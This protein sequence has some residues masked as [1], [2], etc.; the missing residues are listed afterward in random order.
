VA[1]IQL[2]EGQ[3]RRYRWL[4]AETFALT[5]GAY[6]VIYFC[7]KNF[8]VA[9]DA[10][11]AEH[12]LTNA[13]LGDLDSGYLVAYAAGQ[14]LSGMLGD[15]IG[16]K[17]LVGFGLLATAAMNVLF[18]MGQ[19]FLFF[20]AAWT[21]NGVA[22]SSGWPGTLK[23]LTQWYPRGE[24]GTVLGIW[25]TCYQVGGV[26]ATVLATWLLVTFG[27]QSAFFGPAVAVAG[28]ALLFLSLQKGSPEDEGLPGPEV[29]R[30]EARGEPPPPAVEAP[31]SEGHFWEGVGHVLRSGPIWTLGFTYV[32]LKF[33]R[34]SFLFWLPFYMSRELGYSAGEAGYSS[35]AF[36]L[37]GVGGTVIAGLLSDRLFQSRRAPIVV[38]M[39]VLLAMATWL[40]P[41]LSAA[42]RAANIFGMVLIGFLLYGPDSIASGAAAVDFGHRRGASLATGFV[43]G[44]GSIGAALSGVVVGRVSDAYGWEAVFHLFP[45]LCIVGAL[46]MMTMWR[47]VPEPDAA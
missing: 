44:M 13:Q 16:G 30:A 46:L 24:R 31:P 35:T 19:S 4:R 15:R 7:R 11:G 33:V 10:I 29:Y 12:A 2:T 32:V 47:R 42:G 37:A 6:A 1:A 14:F 36:D 18:G 23:T 28:F 40:Y 41:E 3:K 27:W 38:I 25:C 34:Y 21:L 8:S 39:M 17:R 26:L 43:N 45:P 20:L 22:Q 9:K 5:W